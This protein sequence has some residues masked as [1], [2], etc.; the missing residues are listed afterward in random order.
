[1]NKQYG[2]YAKIF[3]ALSDPKRVR[4]VDLLSCGEMCGCVLLKCFEVTQPTLA[5]DMKVLTEA[6]VVTSR[7]EGKRTLYS[8]NMKTLEDIRK[9]IDEIQRNNADKSHR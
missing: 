9:H 5:H 6:G 4:I 8:L 1:M 2:N 3:K 7:R